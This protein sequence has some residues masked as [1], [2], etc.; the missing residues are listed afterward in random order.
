MP[1]VIDK[2]SNLEASVERPVILDIIRQVME[3][4]QISS[5]TPVRFYGDEGKGA[6]KN[7][8]IGDDGKGENRWNFDD[9]LAIDVDED[10]ERDRFLSTAI[11]ETENQFIFR[12]SHLN[13]AMKPVYASTEV[14]INFRYR[15]RDKNQA[16]RWRN[17]IRARCSMQRGVNI[18]SVTYHYQIPPKLLVLLH[19]IHRLRELQAGYG[20]NFNTYLAERLT[21]KATVV[22]N[23]SGSEAHW[24]VGETQGRIQGYFEFEGIPDRVEKDGEHDTYTATFSYRFHYDKP[25]H[26]NLQYPIVVHQQLL[27]TDWRPK[28]R[29]FK[30]SDVPKT[31]TNSALAFSKFE[32]DRQMLEIQSNNGLSI[33]H[34]DEFVPSQ[35]IHGTLRVITALSCISEDDKRSLFNLGELGE[36]FA[37]DRDVL[38]FIQKSEYPFMG[39]P[40]HSI[41]CLTLYENRFLRGPDSVKIDENLEVK[42]STDLSMRTTHRVRLSLVAD[43][44]LL[45]REAKERLKNWPVAGQKILTAINAGLSDKGG[46]K[47]LGKNQLDHDTLCS[48]N[49]HYEN[50][51]TEFD[52]VRSGL[53][54]QT[55][56]R[57]VYRIVPGPCRCG[58]LETYP[59]RRGKCYD[60]Q[61][62]RTNLVQTL[63]VA[64]R[65]VA[66][67]PDDLNNNEYPRSNRN[68]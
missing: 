58:G 24:A 36:D 51:N 18:H 62:V 11:K 25:I 28:E 37:M 8:T 66:S 60:G 27:S 67:L 31:Y 44:S 15:A 23:Q 65:N 46:Q 48:L 42:A 4:T 49:Y 21:T 10:F 41:L 22:T 50:T 59:T 6:Q 30:P 12:D 40:Y 45:T 29:E 14:T 61:L 64:V 56:S 7:S 3:I 33:P 35:I 26:C 1:N 43:L 9:K 19:E 13:V 39:R 2:V 38:E 32:S 53:G 5:Q 54:P 17:E 34:F 55:G 63:F 16:N 20:E 68:P 52:Y 57:R 47:D